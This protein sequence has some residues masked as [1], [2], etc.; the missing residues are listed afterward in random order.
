MNQTQPRL[1]AERTFTA[2]ITSETSFGGTNLGE[3]EST[4]T[5]YLAKDATGYIEWDIPGTGD[6]V[7]IGLWFEVEP[8]Q[9]GFTLALRDYDGVFSLP[10]QAI[11]MLT[12]NGILVSDDFR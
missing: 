3:H 1:I 10:T 2:H 11:E 8:Y 6:F 7:S 9:G 4:M 12:D 5:L